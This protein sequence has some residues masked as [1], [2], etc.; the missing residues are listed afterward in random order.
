MENIVNRFADIY[1]KL[2]CKEPNIEFDSIFNFT[3]ASQV[4]Y[5]LGFIFLPAERKTT[6]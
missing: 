4:F 1:G 6:S 5:A 2:V 3:Y